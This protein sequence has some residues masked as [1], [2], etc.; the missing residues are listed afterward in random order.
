VIVSE[1]GGGGSIAE[2]PKGGGGGG[3]EKSR[4]CILCSVR[5]S[6][7]AQGLYRAEKT[8]ISKGFAQGWDPGG[9]KS[10]RFPGEVR[11]LGVKQTKGICT[12]V[13]G[14]KKKEGGIEHRGPSA[15]RKKR[16]VP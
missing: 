2:G 11:P 10:R 14:P 3:K 16:V 4:G 8:P 7:P 5:V 15:Q 1:K 6:D 13:R 12:C 9:E